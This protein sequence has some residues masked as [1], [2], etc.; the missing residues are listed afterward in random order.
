MTKEVPEITK[1]V[2]PAAGLGTRMYPFTKEQ[3]KLII[4]ILNKPVIEYLLEELT[5]SGIKEIVIVSNHMT[6]LQKLFKHDIHLMEMLKRLKKDTA[7][8]RIKHLESLGKVDL[9]R[10]DEP[11][12]WLHEVLHAKQYLKKAP[13]LMSFSDVLYI[14]K[15]PAAKQ[16]IDIYKR[17][18]KNV[19]ANT[20]YVLKP[21]IFDLLEKQEFKEGNDYNGM[22]I[23]GHL[24]NRNQIINYHIRGT[25]CDMGDPLNYLKS[26]T[27]FGLND[28]NIRQEYKNFLKT[29]CP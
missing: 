23:L 15:V 26:Q 19:N 8:K 1:A 17:T 28:L 27:L 12:G 25:F 2:I 22:W 11:M 24:G 18:G 10:Q 29:L 16:V 20:R 21:E 4:P 7:L 14:S 13:F 5:A 3:P 9:V 6:E